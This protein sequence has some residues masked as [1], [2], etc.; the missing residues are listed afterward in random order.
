ML[1]PPHGIHSQQSVG[2]GATILSPDG[3]VPISTTWV[4]KLGR[5]NECE[6][7]LIKT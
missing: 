2:V 6:L 1:R 4:R 3:F 7:C 5:A